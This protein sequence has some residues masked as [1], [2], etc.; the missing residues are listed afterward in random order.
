MILNLAAPFPPT[1]KTT[2]MVTVYEFLM[3]LE[4][5]AP[6]SGAFKTKK[7]VTVLCILYDLNCLRQSRHHA[8]KT[9]FADLLC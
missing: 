9:V 2:E 5:T 8:E 1:S 3:I 4:L 7:I 6:F